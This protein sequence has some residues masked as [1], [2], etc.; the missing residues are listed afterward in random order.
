MSKMEFLSQNPAYIEHPEWYEKEF[1]IDGILFYR[2][3]D[4]LNFIPLTNL[5]E[6]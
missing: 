3:E 4:F 6:I 1:Y 5:K 2:Y